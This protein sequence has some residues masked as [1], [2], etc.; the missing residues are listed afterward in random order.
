VLKSTIIVLAAVFV[1]WLPVYLK[2]VP[3][4]C[5]HQ[6]LIPTPYHYSSAHIFCTH[7]LSLHMYLEP[8]ISPTNPF[9]QKCLERWWLLGLGKKICFRLPTDPSFWP[10][11]KSFFC[12]IK[13]VKKSSFT[14]KNSVISLTYLKKHNH[15]YI[16]MLRQKKCSFPIADRP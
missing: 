1:M 8:N 15:A 14:K 12:A 13:K 2:A 11:L 3:K 6:S 9:S 16:F 4:L 7:P 5:T 10:R